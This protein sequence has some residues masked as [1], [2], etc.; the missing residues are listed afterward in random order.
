LVES[1]SSQIEL[2]GG[3]GG[4]GFIGTL[5]LSF[6]NFS[7]GNIFKGE[8]YKPVPMGDGQTFALRLQASR[9][10]RVYSLNFSEP[11]LG[12]KKPVRFNLSVSRTQQFGVTRD[13]RGRFQPN[14]DQQFSITGVTLG[15]A[16]RVQWPDDFFTISHSV[17]YQL[18]D[19]R[20]YNIGLFKISDCSISVMVN[21]TP[22]PTLWEF[23]EMQPLGGVFF[24]GEVQIL[25]L[26]LSLLLPIRYSAIKILRLL[27]IE[28]KNLIL[29]ELTW[30]KAKL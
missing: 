8:A 21:Q 16:K 27:E 18:Y 17:G 9:T 15:L 4:G 26:L 25:R 23:L 22:L 14:K 3:Y 24:Q 5:G 2:Q 11:W 10:F 19:F 30:L 29:K 20:N 6:S 1:G 28:V 12:G 13:E 7:I